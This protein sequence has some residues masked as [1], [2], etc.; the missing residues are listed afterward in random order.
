MIAVGTAAENGSS[1]G[2]PGR[3]GSERLRLGRSRRVRK[4][5]EFDE[6]F[7]TGR[8]H[9]GRYLVLR[10]RRGGNAARRVG[11]IASK[12][13][14]RRAVDRARAKRLL[15]EAFR[16]SRGMLA[17]DVDLVLVARRRIL[18]ATCRDVRREL[19][20]LVERAHVSAARTGGG[21]RHDG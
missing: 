16:L 5:S 10:Y 14:F 6:A 21:R 13:T 3:S 11:V 12:R 20:K 17:D 1:D 7:A 15:R 2:S 19:V 4:A 18:E 9:A 8:G